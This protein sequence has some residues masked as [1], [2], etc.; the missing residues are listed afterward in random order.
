MKPDFVKNDGKYIYLIA[1][2]A[3][4]I[5]DAYPAEQARIVSTTPFMESPAEIF[6]EGDRLVVFANGNDE[7]L[8]QTCREH[9]S[10][11]HLAPGDKSAGIRYLGPDRTGS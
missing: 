4:V 3:L 8:H 2:R 7:H 6:L 10:S 9:R 5:I 1:D 11:P